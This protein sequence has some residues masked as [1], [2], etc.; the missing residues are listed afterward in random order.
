MCLCRPD[1]RTPFCGRPG[2]EWPVQDSMINEPKIPCILHVGAVRFD[3][4]VKVS[5]AQGAIN[6][7]HERMK[8]FETLLEDANSLLRSAHSIAQREG[9]Q[10]NW[11]AFGDQVRDALEAQHEMMHPV[12][13][14]FFNEIYQPSGNPG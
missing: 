5:T 4:G 8:K 12:A 6:R 2:C 3:V 10:T 11:K 9:I 7:L 1:I 13:R 14:E